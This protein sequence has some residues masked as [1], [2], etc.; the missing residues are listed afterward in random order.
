M[1]YNQLLAI[2]W[3]CNA[4]AMFIMFARLAFRKLRKERFEAGD[5]LTMGAIASLLVRHTLTHVSTIWGTNQISGKP[6]PNMSAEEIYEREI[7]SKLRLASRPFLNTYLWLLKCVLL[8]IY[9]RLL[10]NVKHERAILIGAWTFLALTYIA[11]QI[12]TFTDCNPFDLYWIVL[13]P[14]GD[15]VLAYQQ[16]FTLGILNIFTDLVLIWLPLQVIWQVKRP[17]LE[18]F[19]LAALFSTGLFVVAITSFRIQQNYG[20]NGSQ[21]SRATWVA[22]E[23]LA[24][25]FVANAPSM[26]ILYRQR[27]E[28]NNSKKSWEVRGDSGFGHGSKAEN[29]GIEILIE[30]RIEQRYEM[31]PTLRTIPRARHSSAKAYTTPLPTTATSKTP[32]TLALALSAALIAYLTTSH[33]RLDNGRPA[34]SLTATSSALRLPTASRVVPST[35]QTLTLARAPPAPPVPYTLIGHGVRTVSFLGIHVYVASLYV[36]ADDLPRLQACLTALVAPGGTTLVGVEVEALRA[37]LLAPGPASEHVW[38]VILRDAGVRSL[39]RVVPVRDTDAVHLR[40]GWVRAVMA[41]IKAGALGEEG[42]GGEA[43]GNAVAAFKALF[44]ARGA[45]RKRSVLLLERGVEGE[46]GVWCEEGKGG[47]KVAGG[48]VEEERQQLVKLGAV[49]DERVSRL[50][51]LGYLQGKN[52]ASEELRKS[53][54]EGLAELAQR[55]VGS[56]AA[57]AVAV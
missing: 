26:Y 7:G 22:V 12:T 45:L 20:T 8:V 53:V 42:D 1:A 33:L 37:M 32:L 6:N 57:A 43:L 25:A 39:L 55:P 24:A 36:A 56:G 51:W 14:P 54:V 27:G 23:G 46:L 2:L 49:L 35:P 41:R 28:R 34:P 15:C 10:R 9:H 4:G 11:A 48:T 16:L 5:Y 29:G 13:P 52:V 50:V 30:S 44:S 18:K 40:D 38:R 47:P 3:G 21:A 17:F 19:Q 31:L